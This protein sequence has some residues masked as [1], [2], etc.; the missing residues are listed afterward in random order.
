ML[1]YFEHSGE[2]R[3]VVWWDVNN[4]L[5]DDLIEEFEEQLMMLTIQSMFP[6]AQQ[7]G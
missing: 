1:A 3:D 6:A 4:V 7:L 2:G 5:V